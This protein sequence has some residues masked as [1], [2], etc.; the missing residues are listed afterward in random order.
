MKD[1]SFGVIPILKDNNNYLFLLIRHTAGHWAFPKGHPKEG[2][3][4]IDTARREFEEETGNKEY[5]LLD[6]ISFVENYTFTENNELIEKTVKYFLAIVENLQIS[7]KKEEIQ[8]YRWLNFKE[9]LKLITFNESK[10]ILIKVK[11]YL[12][13]NIKS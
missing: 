11:R 8:D 2:E 6:D 9:S 13:G 4:E 12:D 3:I 5:S 7:V 10:G 1:K